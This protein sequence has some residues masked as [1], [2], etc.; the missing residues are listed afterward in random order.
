VIYGDERSRGEVNRG[1]ERRDD[2][3]NARRRDD[4]D[5]ARAIPRDDRD[6]SS[7]SQNHPGWTQGYRDG[8]VKGREDAA[9]NRSYDPQRHQWYR[10]ASRGY[11]ARYGLRG[12]YASIYRDGFD[13][14]YGEQFRR[15]GSAR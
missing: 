10:S 3:A 13:A 4:D 5:R 8:L 11:E 9:R 1:E 2:G 14:G 7:P 15:A 6:R 12:A